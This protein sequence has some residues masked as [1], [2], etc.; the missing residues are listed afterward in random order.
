MENEGISLCQECQI[1][2]AERTDTEKAAFCP[3]CGRIVRYVLMPKT[4]TSPIR[5][6]DHKF[7]ITVALCPECGE[8]LNPPGLLDQNNEELDRQYREAVEQEYKL[9]SMKSC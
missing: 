3:S 2:R 8:E 1:P 9:G 4:L 7:R 5:G 6:R